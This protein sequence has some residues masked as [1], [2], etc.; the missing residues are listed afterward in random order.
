MEG[1]ARIPVGPPLGNPLPSYW[2]NPKSSLANPKKSK[3]EKLNQLYDYAV[4][5]SGISGTMIA[6]NL[7]KLRP[8]AQIV[9]L[10]AREICSGAT[11]RNGGHTKAASYRTYTHHVQELGKAEALKIAR[12]EYAN[13]IDTHRLAKE[14]GVDCESKLCDTVD[15]IYD[16]ATLEL[17]KVAIQKLRADAEEDEKDDGGMACYEIL[18]DQKEVKRRY[19]VASENENPILAEREEIAGAFKYLAGRIHAYRFTTSIL[20]DCVKQGLQL[21]TNTPVHDVRP[22]QQS[23]EDGKPLWDVFTQQ[24]AL[25][26]R[27]V[28]A[29]TN[30]YTP[31]F[32]KEL[33]G[34]IVP[35]R[36]QITAQQS[37]RATKLPRLLPTTYSFIYRDG[38]EYMIPRPLPDGGQHIVI[39]GGLGRLSDAG[40]SEYG[41]VDD[42]SL[43]PKIST[44]LRESLNGYF[45]AET[46]GETSEDE[47]SQRV[48]QEWTGI[49]GATADGRP[50]V[51][52]VPGKK[53]LWVSAGFNGH[54]MVLCLKSAEALVTMIEE[55]GN[56]GVPEWFPESFLITEERLR[57]CK[58]R[59]RTDM[60]VPT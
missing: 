32:L 20:E 34:A 8:D 31:Y 37:G 54:G 18:E 3:T 17:G 42:S 53:S 27:N 24:T 48:V 4:I 46:W 50:F 11:G 6:Y 59:G 22:S 58:F 51:G 40:A 45:G 36:G 41:F 23:S 28:I 38:Y 2:H 47:A 14:T 21:R 52:E 35:M 13:I 12:L 10:D 30:G 19:F 57:K 56:E 44:Y 43:N 49:M 26:A 33:Q 55:G 1:R 16:K 15:L 39:G 5:G 7:L 25:T 29:A 60:Q 9:M